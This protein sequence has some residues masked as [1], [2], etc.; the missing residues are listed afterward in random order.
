MERYCVAHRGYSSVAPENTLAAI[1]LAIA[2][3]CVSW[4]EVDVRMSKDGVPVLIHDYSVNRTTNGRGAVRQLTLEQLRKLDAGSWKSP[5]YKGEQIPTLDELLDAAKGKVKLNLEIKTQNGMSPGLERKM[6]EAI[7]QRGMEKDVVLTSF[8]PDALRVIRPIDSE[9]STGL[10]IENRTKD[11]FGKL[12]DLGCNFLSIKHRLVNQEIV[13]E[14]TKRS[15]QLMVWTVDR[16]NT[17]RRLAQLDPEILICTNRPH[18]YREI[19][20]RPQVVKESPNWW[21]MGGR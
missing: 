16:E 10:I 21:K 15:I 2:E 9:I 8:A 17:M 11:L 20:T 5:Q 6:I 13:A 4:I 7:R 19:H 14:A 18:V 3:P 1:Q 12:E